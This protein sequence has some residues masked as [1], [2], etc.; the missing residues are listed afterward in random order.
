MTRN[1]LAYL[2]V[3][4]ATMATATTVAA[5]PPT[6]ILRRLIRSCRSR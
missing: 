1:P 2:E 3:L 6:A 4:F 5:S